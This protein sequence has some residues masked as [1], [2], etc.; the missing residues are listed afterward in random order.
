MQ[1]KASPFAAPS[2]FFILDNHESGTITPTLS[3]PKE[4]K[5]QPKFLSGIFLS[6]PSPSYIRWRLEYVQDKIIIASDKKKSAV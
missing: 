2:A 3:I 6:V 5:F 1:K 4:A